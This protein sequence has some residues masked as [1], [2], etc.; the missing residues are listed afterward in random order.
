MNDRTLAPRTCESVWGR[1]WRFAR[2]FDE[3]VHTDGTARLG[4]RVAKLERE[5]ADR[6]GPQGGRSK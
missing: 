5:L 1:I 3:A 2:A 4:A 6:N